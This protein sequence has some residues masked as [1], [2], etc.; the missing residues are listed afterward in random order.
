MTIETLPDLFCH[1]A[2]RHRKPALLR[3][4]TDSAWRDVS[5]DTFARQVRDLAHGLA[6][7]GI[8]PGDRV[9]LISANRPEWPVSD[10]AIAC[11]GAVSVPLY[12]TLPPDQ[13]HHI[14][15]DSGAAAVICGDAAL[16]AKVEAVRAGC[17]ALRL[18]VVIDVPAAG[19]LPD[20]VH[21]WQTLLDDG[22]RRAGNVPPADRRWARAPAAGDLATLIYTSGTTGTP[23][24]VML[25]HGNLAS[26]VVAAT[27]ALRF[28]PADRAL[29]FLPLSHIFGRHV[30]FGMLSAGV[31]IAYAESFDAVPHNL[32]EIEPTVVAAVPRF[33][34][35]MYVR[36]QDTLAQL[37]P[38]RRL[39]FDRALALG[40]ERLAALQGGPPLDFRRRARWAWYSGIVFSRLRERLGG[41]LRF[42]ISGG[43]PLPRAIAE[44]FGAA[45]VLIL[46]G[47]GLTEAS[48][49]I[50]VNREEDFRFGAVGKPLP[51]VE[52]RLAGDGEILVRG[53]NVMKGYYNMPDATAGALRDGWLHTGDV[54]AIDPG[55][56]LR[57]TDRKKDLLKTAGGK[58]IAPQPIEGRLKRCPLVAH[59]VVIADGRKCATA[60]I[61]PDFARLEADARAQDI[62]VEPRAAMLA[63]PTVRAVFQ[64]A[65]DDANQGLA[66]FE[67]IKAFALVEN[68]FTIDT[69]ELT[70]TLKVKRRVVQEKYRS[71]IDALYSGL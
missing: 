19:T 3:H 53:P 9:A 26:N 45:G 12:T 64:K 35:K 52:V 43:A 11:A 46:E 36:V 5:T 66:P 27:Q 51:G 67:T 22:E 21:A 2:T 28:S 59:A 37:P 17:P 61:V 63:H 62:P 68:D 58:Y 10:F 42:F 33:F 44:F 34:E 31:T 23:K 8:G 14:L 29:S 57:I 7:Y 48:P 30:D 4:K 54:G 60:L 69:G 16:L 13:V 55:G 41:H 32:V 25:T 24:G 15:A 20:G 65:V 56:F 1:I 39:L 49:V 38:K 47:Y 18:R 50:A 71:T 70:P 40:R 6:A